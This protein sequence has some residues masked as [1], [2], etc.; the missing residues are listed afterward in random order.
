MKSITLLGKRWFQKSYG[1]TYHTVE[2][3]VD[4]KTV[5]Y[6]PETYGYDSQYE[7]TAKEWLE[8][9]GLAKGI[10]YPIRIWA[11]ENGIEYTS[12]VSDVSRE[13]DL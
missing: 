12:R 6:S 8:S 3:V 10:T 11:E 2:V 4:G 9:S 13:R 7:Q 5:F 1:N